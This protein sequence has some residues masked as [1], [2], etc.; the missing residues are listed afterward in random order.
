M[1]LCFHFGSTLFPLCTPVPD[2][3]VCHSVST[4]LRPCT[5]IPDL[6]V[7]HSVSAFSQHFNFTPSVLVTMD[8]RSQPQEHPASRLRSQ[9]SLSLREQRRLSFHSRKAQRWIDEINSAG[10]R[11]QFCDDPRQRCANDRGIFGRIEVGKKYVVLVKGP[12][13]SYLMAPYCKLCGKWVLTDVHFY[14]KLHLHKMSSQAPCQPWTWKPIPGE[15]VQDLDC[16]NHMTFTAGTMLTPGI[17]RQR[18]CQSQ[19]DKVKG[20]RER[21]CL[22]CASA[23]RDF[24]KPGPQLTP[25]I[26]SPDRTESPDAGPQLTPGI[27]RKQ[28]ITSQ[29]D[30]VKRY[31]ERAC[32]PCASNKPKLPRWPLS[33][34]QQTEEQKKDQQER[35]LKWIAENPRPKPMWQQRIEA[36]NEECKAEAAQTQPEANVAEPFPGDEVPDWD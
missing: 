33:E 36:G 15:E 2:L 14:T 7:C 16:A 26:D 28:V 13:W 25:G 1:I 3:F 8:K 10:Q 23:A 17:D 24:N 18:A 29:K 35:L 22:P 4:S 12:K 5:P 31:R 6:F 11:D 34:F 9:D 27:D 19:K 30:K 32:L 21:A 20:Y